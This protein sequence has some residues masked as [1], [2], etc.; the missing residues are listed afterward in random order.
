M[1]GRGIMMMVRERVI[2]KNPKKRRRAE[3]TLLTSIDFY[4]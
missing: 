3:R 4:E 1:A 2:I